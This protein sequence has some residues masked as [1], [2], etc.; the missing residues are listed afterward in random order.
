MRLIEQY[1]LAAALRL[2]VFI[3]IFCGWVEPPME[4]RLKQLAVTA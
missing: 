3:R 4:F 2:I 1:A